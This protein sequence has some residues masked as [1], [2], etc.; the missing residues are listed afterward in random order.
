VAIVVVLRLCCFL[1]KEMLFSID[2]S[3]SIKS[4]QARAQVLKQN[5]SNNE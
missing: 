2:N 5:T 1:I 3:F 4:A